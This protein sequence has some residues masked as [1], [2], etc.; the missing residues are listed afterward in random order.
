MRGDWAKNGLGLDMKLGTEM[1]HY[2]QN[3][4]YCYVKKAICGS[5]LFFCWNDWFMNCQVLSWSQFWSIYSQC[6]TEPLVQLRT[7][8]LLLSIH[9]KNWATVTAAALWQMNDSDLWSRSWFRSSSSS[10]VALCSRISQHVKLRQTGVKMLQFACHSVFMWNQILLNSNGQ[11]VSLLELLQ[12]P[13]FNFSQFEPFRM[14]QIY[15]NS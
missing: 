11:K 8:I 1:K 3:D 5:W 12:V 4:K 7:W 6:F 10:W 13:N 9:T 2:D 14:F 15:Q